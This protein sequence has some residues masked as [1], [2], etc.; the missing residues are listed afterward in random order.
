MKR[1]KVE[2]CPERHCVVDNRHLA[3]DEAQTCVWC[4]GRTRANLLAVVD[5][6]ELLPAEVTD[7]GGVSFEPIPTGG[8]GEAKLLGGD[9]LVLLAG[10]NADGGDPGIEHRS[11]PVPPLSLLASW[12]DDWRKVRGQPAAGKATM[13]T[14]VAYLGDNLG[15]A[16]QEHPVFAEFSADLRV[17]RARLEA[18]VKSGDYLDHGSQ[19]PCPECGEPLVRRYR[20][21]EPCRHVPRARTEPEAVTVGT[22]RRYG[23]TGP[24]RR[25]LRPDERGD[26]PGPIERMWRPCGCS[27]GGRTDDWTCPSKACARIVTD[28]EY[29]LA[30]WASLLEAKE[31]GRSA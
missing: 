21:P 19:I 16:A 18:V 22:W 25:E 24:D 9:A 13:A 28:A 31:R 30:M 26:P 6:Y 29:G 1:C 4:L 11:D 2:E 15:W 14:V 8:T 20:D 5:A 12:E 23:D 27:Q 17:L 10:G 7:R 3:D